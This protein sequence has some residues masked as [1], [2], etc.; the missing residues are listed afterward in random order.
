MPRDLLPPSALF[1]PDSCEPEIFAFTGVW[2]PPAPDH[3]FSA[4]DHN[5]VTVDSQIIDLPLEGRYDEKAGIDHSQNLL[6]RHKLVQWI[7]HNE[8]VRPQTRHCSAIVFSKRVDLLRAEP[9]NLISRG[10][11]ACI[12][13][14]CHTSS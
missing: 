1:H 2:H 7:R 6:L 12:R 10:I 8:I 13:S 9:S 11:C 5:Y 3:S 14:C 4:G